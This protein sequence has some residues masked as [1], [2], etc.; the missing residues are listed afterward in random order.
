MS[1]DSRFF[2]YLVPGLTFTAELLIYALLCTSIETK[3]LPT[4]LSGLWEKDNLGVAPLVVLLIS[5]GGVGYI[6]SLLHHLLLYCP[7]NPLRHV[8][9]GVDYRPFLRKAENNL[10]PYGAA[11]RLR[12]LGEQDG[13][14]RPCV[15]DLSTEGVWRVISCLWQQN[16]RSDSRIKAASKPVARLSDLMHASGGAFYG[17]LAALLIIVSLDLKYGSPLADLAHLWWYL[18]PVS[19]LILQGINF[20]KTAA[21][22]KVTTEMIL[23]DE[24]FSQSEEKVVTH[25]YVQE[26][27]LKRAKVPEHQ[28]RTI[29][30]FFVRFRDRFPYVK[31]A[32]RWG[33]VRKDLG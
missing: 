20:H 19:V 24:V 17:S 1:G 13:G 32:I 7:R 14:C 26:A 3:D 6:L 30:L 5:A 31:L 28:W 15:A 21:H 18:L 10:P 8:G 2:R 25:V 11:L 12:R 22:C 29:F 33:C 16:S 4:F 23:W 9:L 27:D